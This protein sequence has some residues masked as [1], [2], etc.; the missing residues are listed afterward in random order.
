MRERVDALV[1]EDGNERDGRSSGPGLGHMFLR[2]RDDVLFLCKT[3]RA[4]ADLRE[5]SKVVA[6]E[7]SALDESAQGGNMT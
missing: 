5:R 2:Q 6:G 1:M 3:V 7:F 4:L